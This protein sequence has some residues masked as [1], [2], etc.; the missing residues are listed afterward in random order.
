MSSALLLIL[1]CISFGLL[2]GICGKRPEDHYS[3]D[4]D[5]CT[6][7][8]GG[9]FL[10]V[11]VWLMFLLGSVIM[12]LTLALFLVGTATHAVICRPLNDPS[13]DQ[14][15]QLIDKFVDLNAIYQ[16]KR[17]DINLSEIIR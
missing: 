17:V 15:F 16:G 5:L 10:M 8:A 13:H 14:V 3:E 11:A 4:G 1:L 12:V 6:T 7:V 9:R 2:C